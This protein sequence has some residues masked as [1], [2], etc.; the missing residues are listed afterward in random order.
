MKEFY[1]IA[2]NYFFRK[3]FWMI[4]TYKMCCKISRPFSRSTL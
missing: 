3:L 1:I 4:W 2:Y